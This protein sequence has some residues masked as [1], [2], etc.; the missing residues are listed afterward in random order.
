L[1]YPNAP[2][3]PLQ[4]EY[5][6]LFQSKINEFTTEMEKRLEVWSDGDDEDGSLA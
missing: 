2:S 3:S 5:L 6:E 1:T 4:K